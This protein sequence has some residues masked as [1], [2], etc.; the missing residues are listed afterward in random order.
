MKQLVRNQVV[1]TAPGKAWSVLRQWAKRQRAETLLRI[2]DSAEDLRV[3][4]PQLAGQLWQSA[5]QLSANMGYA[6]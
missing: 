3:S 6:P 2:L 1:R 4:Q 5:Q